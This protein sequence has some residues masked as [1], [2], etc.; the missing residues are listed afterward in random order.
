MEGGG[1]A[2]NWVTGLGYLGGCVTVGGE[3]RVRA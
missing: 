3:I 1:L 2:V